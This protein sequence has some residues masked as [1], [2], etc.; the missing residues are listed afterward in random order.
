MNAGR[1]ASFLERLR[2]LVLSVRRLLSDSEVE[3]AIAASLAAGAPAATPPGPSPAVVVEVVEDA[4][5]LALFG[6][7]C[8]AIGART[9][10]DTQ[11]FFFRSLNVGEGASLLRLINARLLMGPLHSRKWG[12]LYRSFARST[13]YHCTSLRPWQDLRDLLRA[14]RIWKSLAVRDDLLALRIDDVPVGDL[15]NDSFLRFKPAATVDLADRYL[16]VVLWQACRD[17]RR[18]KAYFQSVRPRLF[19][20]SYSTYIQ[21][22]VAVRVA[23]AEGIAV[24]SFGNLQ[25]FSKRL[26]LADWLHTRDPDGY[27]NCFELLPHKPEKLEAADAAMKRRVLGQLDGATAYMRASAYAETTSEVPDVAGAVVVFLHDFYD[28][29]HIYRDMVFPDFWE[30]ACFTIDALVEDGTKFLVK[31]H[32]NQVASSNEVMAHLQRRYPGLA[33]VPQEVTNLQLARAGMACGI[34]V[35]G[36]VAHEMAYLGIPTI[37]C[38]R[39]PH[40]SF[41][42]CVTASSRQ[43]Y[44][45]ALRGATTA[46]A[47]DKARAR[48]QSLRFYHM[49]NSSL[50]QDH[51]EL[52]DANV[53]LGRQL[54]AGTIDA[55]DAVQSLQRLASL[56]G[57][58]AFARQ[59][60]EIVDGH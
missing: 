34:T 32:P 7:L 45:T 13:A 29:P 51:A 55:K 9:P 48:E 2:Q 41:D 17:L 40:V 10:V 1:A 15:V 47:F 14:R 31:P 42:F 6:R 5:F 49:H 20:T 25:E 58:H 3:A 57:F 28:S 50:D 39:H 18:A 4:H 30:W 59:C 46:P 8:M 35:Y 52:R 21:H 36:T 37:S 12:R 19:L 33:V 43:A 22:G 24:F 56:P 26:S 38:A 44:R 11:L 54:D 23:L 53:A 60:A 16:L 27:A